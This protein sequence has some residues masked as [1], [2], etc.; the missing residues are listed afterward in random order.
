MNIVSEKIKSHYDTLPA[1]ERLV[2]DYVLENKDALFQH[3]IKELATLSGTT[4]AAWTR[5]A[6]AIGYTGLKDLKNAYYAEANTTLE[7][8][9]KGGPKIAFK[10][11]NEYTSLQ[12]IADNICAT[13]VQAVQTTYRLFDAGTFSETVSDIVKAKQIQVFG[14]GTASVAAYDLYCKLRRIHYNVVFNHDHHMNLMTVSQIGPEDAA[15]FFSDNAKNTEIMQLF[16]IAKERKAVTIAVT[17]L[18][19][20]ALTTGCDHVLFATS[21]EIDKKSGITSSRFAQLFIVDTL[22]TAI[23]NRDY[24]NIKGYLKSS[25]DVFHDTARE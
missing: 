6:Q 12:S 13:S 9:D 1:S 11:V 4:Q 10:D 17:K 2:A 18:G 23:A 14:V 7:Q 25:Y 22:Y 15:I 19:N 20:N 16:S 3:P 21:P 5:F 8:T 24:E